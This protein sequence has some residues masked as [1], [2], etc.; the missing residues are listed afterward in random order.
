M[1]KYLGKR[2][3]QSIIA[4]LGVTLVVFL[5]LNV[6]GDPVTLMLP[7][8]ASFEEIEALKAKLGYDDPVFVQYFRFLGNALRGDFGLSYNYYQ[9]ALSVVLER[10]PATATLA[11]AAFAVSLLISIPAGIVAAVRRNSKTDAVIRTLA[12][13]GQCVPAFWLGIMLML[14]FSVKLK[15]LPTS[16][17]ES[18]SALILPAATLG[19]FSAATFTRMLRSNMIEVMGKEYIDTARSKGLSERVVVWKHAFKNALSS[20]LTVMGLQIAGLL[21]GAVITE[22]V[23]AWPGIGRLLVQSINNSDFNVVEVIVILMATSFVVINFIV[24]VLYC[25]VNPRIQLQ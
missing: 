14:L 9:P 21:G 4:I 23:F 11:L 24:D 13:L 15:L 3:L 17:F 16:G 20:L 8:N 22:T 25:V 18:W 2:L 10:V 5:V 6:A 19:L 12:L 1:A 7:A